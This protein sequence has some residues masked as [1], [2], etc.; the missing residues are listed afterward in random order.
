MPRAAPTTRLRSNAAG[1]IAAAALCGCSRDDMD[2]VAPGPVGLFTDVTES[3]GLRFTHFNGAAGNFYLPET[4]GGGGGFF[5]A[6]GDGDA[7][8]LLVQGGSIP[9][10]E[11]DP[12]LC[13]L[14]NDGK[15]RFTDATVE[16]GLDVRM[17]GMSFAAADVDNDGD[18]D[19]LVT[20][21]DRNR[22][23]LNERGRF[24]DATADVGIAQRGWFSS[25]LFFDYDRD[26]L[27]DLWLARYVDWSPQ[28]ERP[29]RCVYGHGN[30]DYCPVT[31]FPPTA[32]Q[33]YHN[34]G[35]ND[36]GRR[37]VD[38]TAAA[39]VGAVAGKTL[40]LCLVDVGSDGWPDVFVANDTL[41]S[42]LFV[43]RGDGTFVDAAFE[44]GVALDRWGSSFA[45]MGVDATYDGEGFALAVGNFSGEP[46]SY[47]RQKTSAGA[48]S[49]PA[50]LAEP[51]EFDEL[52]RSLGLAAPTIPR[53]TFGLCFLDFDL[54]GDDDLFV[55]NGHV[56]RQ[57]EDEGIA[58]RQPC[59]LFERLGG[60]FREVEGAAGSPIALPIVGRAAACADVDQDGD[61]DLLVVE[62]GG[63][64]RL[65]RNDGAR[66]GRSLRVRLRGAASNRD[67]IGA[68]VTV[69]TDGHTLRDRV[70]V[71]NSY[72]SQSELTLTFGLADASE[73]RRLEVDWPSGQ[74][75]VIEHV[76]AGHQVDVE[77]PSGNV[78]PPP[79]T[80]RSLP[81][82][83]SPPATLVGLTSK[84]LAAMAPQRR[85]DVPWL[86]AYGAALLAEGKAVEALP[87]LREARDQAPSDHVAHLLALRAAHRQGLPLADDLARLLESGADPGFLSLHAVYY[88][89]N[90][91]EYEVAAELL[92]AVLAEHDLPPAVRMRLATCL[93]RA[94]RLDEAIAAFD[95]IARDEPGD[96][97]A[98]LNASDCLLQQG[99]LDRAQ[100]LARKAVE[101][102][103][104]LAMTHAALA[105]ALLPVRPKKA[106]EEFATAKRLAP[107][108]YTI[109]VG[110][111]HAIGASGDL[112]GLV[113]AARKLRS[114]FPDAPDAHLQLLLV[115]KLAGPPA[116]RLSTARSTAERFTDDAAILIAAAEAELE[117]GGEAKKARRLL[118]QASRCAGDDA[119][120]ASRIEAL[121]ARIDETKKEP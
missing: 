74:R 53:V 26:G 84:E 9:A 40:G 22:F 73:A 80:N 67:A 50:E 51:A 27:L 78:A 41:P 5:D 20:G 19:L 93:Q 106:L 66:A 86:K 16:V 65:L 55:A 81:S 72:F 44:L 108:D 104:D 24:R 56:G 60:R 101:L 36:G 6:D 63:P 70:V 88:L 90:L 54:D 107:M 118:D 114:D 95:E 61:V 43:N 119:G 15:G 49:E 69:E 32:P 47:F 100:E 111:L 115:L 98:P 59:Q 25:A 45:G 17:V 120:A 96:V 105:R 76:K 3:A 33:L 58:Y 52:S 1:L 46:V 82:L 110:H 48:S 57:Q 121:R 97:F 31:L 14:R 21:L 64:A 87:P 112:E 37:F 103:P 92:Q 28:R 12:T 62:N 91:D 68:L 4:M 75:S 71:G 102:R 117:A 113:P 7:D 94:G 10:E 2:A 89:T 39:G 77:E 11:S 29:D 35:G 42:Q 8:L 99:K 30:R 34:E 23:F 79:T 116:Q 83:P 13:F 18:P 109:R 38:V 85:D